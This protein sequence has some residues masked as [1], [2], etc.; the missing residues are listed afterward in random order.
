MNSNNNIEQLMQLIPDYITGEISSSDKLMLEKA[1]NESAELRELYNEM[2]GTLA[3]VRRHVKLKEP[4]E[5]YWNSLLP[6]IHQRIEDKE[7]KAFSWDKIPSLWKVLVPI[8]AVVLIALIY[9]LVKPS[10]T[11]I[12]K[13]KEI[14][15]IKKDT[16]KDNIENKNNDNK[17]DNK[18]PP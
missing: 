4:P 13:D 10:D 11:Q 8:A 17:N 12:T 15:N 9:Y 1:M 5:Q 16:N 6:R 3:F 14:E 2:T 18:L 7:S